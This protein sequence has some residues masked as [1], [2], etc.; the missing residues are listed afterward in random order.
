MTCQE[1]KAYLLQYRSSLL[2]ER[3][4][5]DELA[6]WR[7]RAENSTA[8]YGAEAGGGGDGRSLEHAAE[9]ILQVVDELERQR[10]ELAQ[11]RLE[12]GA[13]IASVSDARLRELLMLR[14]IDGR[15]WEQVAETMG[16]NARWVRRLHGH[17]LAKVALESPP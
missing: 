3:R 10:T 9:H 14:Y 13:A 7:A 5:A 15:T 1:K 11:L 17:A 12:I 2:E 16:Y 8:R 6:Q 4:L